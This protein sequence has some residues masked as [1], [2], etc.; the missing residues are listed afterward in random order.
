MESPVTAECMTT[1]EFVLEQI[2]RDTPQFLHIAA[3]KPHWRQGNVFLQHEPLDPVLARR[4]RDL[5]KEF[6]LKRTVTVDVSEEG[7][8]HKN[9]TEGGF[10][11]YG[12]PGVGIWQTDPKRILWRDL[13]IRMQVT[14]GIV[15]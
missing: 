13:R 4:E 11:R 9:Q 1:L 14:T 2:C 5:H 10:G 15:C 3:G 8:P 12:T 7:P 6:L